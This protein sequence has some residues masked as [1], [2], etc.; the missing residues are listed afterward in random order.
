LP[1]QVCNLLRNVLEEVGAYLVGLY[2][3]EKTRAIQITQL[4]FFSVN[5]LLKNGPEYSASRI[6]LATLIDSYTK[7][8]FTP[9]LANNPLEILAAYKT[10]NKLEDEELANLAEKAYIKL[11]ERPFPE[12]E[13]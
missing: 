12:I 11:F 8:H 3:G 6:I 1:E 7:S 5:I 4:F 10:L 9:R 2:Y 13:L